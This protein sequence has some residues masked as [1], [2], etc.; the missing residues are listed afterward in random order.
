MVLSNKLNGTQGAYLTNP[1]ILHIVLLL[2]QW[3]AISRQTEAVALLELMGLSFTSFT[4]A[5]WHSPPLQTLAADYMPEF[6]CGP[7]WCPNAYAP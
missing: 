5:E 3:Q 7:G 2:A 6:S 1:E 4:N